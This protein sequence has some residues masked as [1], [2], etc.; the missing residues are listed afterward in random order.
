MR[1][2]QIKDMD[3]VPDACAV[4]R[5]VIGAVNFHRLFLSERHLQNVRDEVRLDPVVLAELF[6]GARRVEIAQGGEAQPV[7]LVIPA[8]DLLEHQL[9]LPVGIDRTLREGLVDRHALGNAEGRAGRAEDE[10]LHPVFHH[11]VEEIDPVRH[12]VAEIFRRI[13]HRLADQRVGR[14]MHHR[15][16]REFLDRQSHRH[17]V[18]QVGLV[19]RG[20]RIHR[21]AVP[22]GQVVQHRD[23][24]SAVEHFLHADASD[25][26]RAAGD[27]N[28]HGQLIPEPPEP[29]KQLCRP[30][31]CGGSDKTAPAPPCG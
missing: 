27:Q 22:F 14:E 24:V 11:G 17:P 12:V 3:V 21:R 20:P 8:Q 26:A 13:G 6:R 19:K 18:R 7:D 28:F 23:P 5:L 30:A 2:S 1:V 29:I 15:V 16:G 25:V 9:R 10:P 31:R 4:R